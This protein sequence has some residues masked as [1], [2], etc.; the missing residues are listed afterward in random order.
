VSTLLEIA[1]YEATIVA[2]HSSER[3]RETARGRALSD[4]R[5]SLSKGRGAPVNLGS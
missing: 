1:L 4:D 3:R 2:L 5:E